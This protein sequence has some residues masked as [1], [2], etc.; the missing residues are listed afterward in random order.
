MFQPLNFEFYLRLSNTHFQTLRETNLS[1]HTHNVLSCVLLILMLYWKYVA[2]GG[3]QI[4]RQLQ[5]F[6]KG[7]IAADN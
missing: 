7:V 1:I 5:S 3:I 6:P 4:G 2:V